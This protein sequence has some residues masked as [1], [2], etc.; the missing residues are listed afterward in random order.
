[1]ALRGIEDG[2]PDF[3]LFL[4]PD[5]KIDGNEDGC[6]EDDG[7]KADEVAPDK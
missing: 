1:M 5:A 2:I 7:K 3:I 6:V 4:L